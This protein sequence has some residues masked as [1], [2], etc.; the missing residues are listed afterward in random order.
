MGG[1]D[2][3]NVTLNVMQALQRLD[4]DDLTIDLIM[5]PVNPHFEIIA[6]E[7][8]R[9]KASQTCSAGNINLLRDPSMPELMNRADLAITAGGSTCYELALVGVPMM[10]IILAEN[11]QGI[12]TALEEY[13]AAVNLGWHSEL[14]ANKIA[15]QLNQLID[16]PGLRN[17]LCARGR[18]ICDGLGPKRVVEHLAAIS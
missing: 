15:R 13:K 6:Q 14:S 17:D 1:A 5:G 11:Q 16:N 3:G 7:I 2:P 10:I 18:K 4:S 8:A 12:A 9:W